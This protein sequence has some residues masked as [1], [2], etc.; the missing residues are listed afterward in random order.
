MNSIASLDAP[1]PRRLETLSLLHMKAAQH[2]S[3]SDDEEMMMFVRR[4]KKFFKKENSEKG[5][6]RNKGK[7]YEKGQFQRCFKCGKMD[8]LIMDYPLL[9][10]EQ[11]RNSKKQ[12]QLASKAF[13]KSMK[14]TWDETSDEESWLEDGENDNLALMATNFSM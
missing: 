14:A 1:A 5:E 4:F 7:S 6:S 9:K 10:E 2:D 11:R 3:Q 13:K 8:H 12:Q